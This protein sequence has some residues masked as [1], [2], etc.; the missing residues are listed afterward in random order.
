MDRH[1]HNL[2][3][4]HPVYKILQKAYEGIENFNFTAQ[5]RIYSPLSHKRKKYTMIT[6]TL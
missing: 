3:I 4:I 2:P 1:R 6:T 5:C